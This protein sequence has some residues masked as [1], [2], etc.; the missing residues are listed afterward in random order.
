MFYHLQN[1]STSTAN[2]E[3]NNNSSSITTQS[4]YLIRQHLLDISKRNQLL[5]YKEKVRTIHLI[6]SP[7]DQLFKT[8]MR[9]GKQNI[10]VPQTSEL[11]TRKNSRLLKEFALKTPHDEEGLKRRCKKLA[12]ESRSAIEETGH[13]LLY[14]ALGFLEWYEASEATQPIKAP[15]ILIPV[16]LERTLLPAMSSYEYML[17]Y[18]DEGIE[19]NIALA[20]K[21]ANDFNLALPP[22]TEEILPETYLAQV[23]QVI[24]DK[25]GWRIVPDIRLDFFSFTKLVM[26]KDLDNENWPNDAQLTEKVNLKPFL[27]ERPVEKD[28]DRLLPFKT[29][30]NAHIPL[31]LD[32][33][34]SQQAVITAALRE[35]TH[36]V[37]EGPPGT[38]KSQ[39]ISNLIAAAL[40]QGQSVL[41]VAEKKAA[42]DV[43]ATR[44]T[45]AGLG[46][47]CL[48]LHSHKTQ[49]TELH[50]NLKKR[51]EQS[52]EEEVELES[53]IQELE[54]KKQQLQAYANLSNSLVGPHHERI[55]EVFWAVERLR[56][57][58][59]NKALPFEFPNPSQISR[60]EFDNKINE[61]KEFSELYEKLSD[62]VIAHWHGFQVTQLWPGD[63]EA[64]QEA[65][66]NLFLTTQTHEA[67]LDVL[68]EETEIPITK[69]LATL[70]L[71]S[72]I[73]KAVLL[74]LPT[75][76]DSKIAGKLLEKQSL[77]KLRKFQ[78]E[79][80]EYKALLNQAI[81]FLGY[82]KYSIKLLQ[83]IINSTNQLEKLGFGNESPDEL[84]NI[85][86]NIDKL[87]NELQAL[88][89]NPESVNS[90]LKF[91]KL[92]EL[93]EQAPQNLVLYKQPEHAIEAT[94]I[95]FQQAREIFSQ[96]SE[97]WTKQKPYF[98]LNKL[99][100][101]EK[102]AILA[103]DLRKYHKKWFPIFSP[104]YRSTKNAINHFLA[105]DNLAAHD[106]VKK[107]EGLATLKRKTEQESQRTQ[108]QRLFGPLFCGIETDWKTLE[109]L[110]HWAQMLTEVLGTEE[111]QILLVQQSD[112]CRYILKTTALKYEQWLRVTKAATQLNVPVEGHLS[113]KEFVEQLLARR[114]L[115]AELAPNLQRQ[116]PHLTDKHLISIHSAVQNLLKAW[117]IR[118][119]YE[120]HQ[121]LKKLLGKN[122][123]GIDTEAGALFALADWIAKIQMIA[124]LPP[125][126]LHWLMNDISIRAAIFH[127]LLTKNETYLFEFSE[128]CRELAVF[129][130][131]DIQKWFKCG[132]KPCTLEQI[133][134]T[135]HTCQVSSNLLGTLSVFYKLKQELDDM[136][137]SVITEA[138]MNQEIEA[139]ETVL[140]FRY[141]F[142]QA[143]AREL[144]SQHPILAKFTHR[145]YET[146][147]EQFVEL[148][149]Q[150]QKAYQKKMAYQIAQR[151]IP[152]GNNTGKVAHLT[153]KSLLEHELNKKRRHIPI[154]QLV[155][156]SS[157]ALQALK[158]CFMMSPLSV[159]QY[160]A[161]GEIEF[162]L[163][164]MDEASQI[165]PEDALGAIARAQ[166]IVIVGDPKQL[167][168]SPFFERLVNEEEESTRVDGQESILDLCFSI[169]ARGRLRWHYR[170]EQHN[171]I[172]F[173]NHHFYDN[174]LLV[175]PAPKMKSEEEGIQLHYIEKAT[176]LKGRNQKEAESV[177]AAIIAHFNT[178]PDLSLGVATF[179][180]KQQELIR[181]QLDKYCQDNMGLEEK[182][183]ATENTAEPFFIKNLEN[184]QGDERDVIFVSTTYGPDPETG[185]VFQRFG[186]IS[187][188]QGWRRLNVIFT[189]AKK[190]LEL[191][192]ALR[193]SD[194]VVK[195]S[196]KRGV[197]IFKSYLNY[198]ETGQLSQKISAQNTQLDFE[199]VLSKLLKEHGY[200]T[201]AQVGVAGFRIDLGVY[202][203][204][205]PDEYLLGI[206]YDGENYHATTSIQ[207]RDRLR[208]E[209]LE[210]KGWKLHRILSA[211]WYQN[212]EMEI[213]R[214]L[215]ALASVKDAKPKL[216]EVF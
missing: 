5:N 197:E 173:S 199:I 130:E 21:L 89:D 156:R 26:Y 79:Q 96:L 177:V 208:Q 210:R 129:G 42:L 120:K 134:H 128:Y 48:E 50:A 45:Q 110:I 169:Y 166:Q 186:P 144:F 88:L 70:H 44:L 118:N 204:D 168:P 54:N 91:L 200:Q 124:N 29:E 95:I 61:L 154:R 141:A 101:S 27:G 153:E 126:L 111:A 32:A 53:I 58:L 22:F 151:T 57:E 205:R 143:F 132:K 37:I 214:L 12:Q 59:A 38:G 99:P 188:E 90:F 69:D 67:Y 171:L 187:N 201:V 161:P 136:G 10:F 215:Y 159:A 60:N 72:Q 152:E 47:F 20:E 51:L 115:V 117:Q 106:M 148:D 87:D 184:V 103:D 102:I 86:K 13:N 56:G 194:I 127:E 185:K 24:Q 92:K 150:L 98:L 2:P 52:H 16:K 1:S 162:D 4:L 76:P 139:Q 25:P 71:L 157:K 3:M 64:I 207:D 34:S 55:Y 6:E 146:L 179:N 125:S 104:E 116:L 35:K 46:E 11:A 109:E 190:R 198:A 175:F 62:E 43:V 174:D 180:L 137:L 14:L 112:P 140:H 78:L 36:L 131:L 149:K 167:P 66:S 135:A 68:I 145:H 172:A 39:T 165:R 107:L 31:I 40:Y 94:P 73:D 100:D 97:E 176:Y 77:E 63:K 114:D 164:I 158:P 17:S 202:H 170:S 93:A 123:Q 28:V 75:F 196:S 83:Q 160:L 155:R 147:R 41:F 15:L 85:I 82:G 74:P 182:I 33:D 183:K 138:L 133:T 80:K 122:Y 84:M 49:K 9:E 30:E 211:D 65:L 19:T 113:V 192:T 206:E 212:R 191:F 213:E 119:R 7:L 105:T 108:Y 81:K 178:R 121:A 216:E 209:I 18:R 195:N 181:E 23:A 193:A 189:R 163:L 142:Y 203:P 8:L